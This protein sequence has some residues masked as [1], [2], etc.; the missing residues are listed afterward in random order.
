MRKLLL[1]AAVGTLLVIGALP[2]G[3]AEGDDHNCAGAGSSSAAQALGGAF[4][5][6]VASFADQQLVDNFGLAN[7]GAPPRSNP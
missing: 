5:S 6:V 3:A 7:C 2:A 1:G 4:G